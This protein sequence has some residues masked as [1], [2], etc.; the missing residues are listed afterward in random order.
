MLTGF[1]PLFST[2]GGIEWS[3]PD[4]ATVTAAVS[5]AVATALLIFSA[6]FAVR[7]LRDARQTRHGALITDLSRRWDEELIVR[8]QVLYSRYT[9]TGIVTLVEKIYGTTGGASEDELE[10]FYAL[11]AL[12]N[13]VETLA[14]MEQQG[15][16]S[17][18]VI[19]R[20]WGG[21]IASAWVAWER[22][23]R[24][25]RELLPAEPTTYQHFEAL[26][27]GLKKR[28]GAD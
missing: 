8:S 4:W 6:I 18:E 2:A 22:P 7:Q 26:V 1:V 9:E 13:L 19:D 27:A 16:I 23:V 14:V 3:K 25:M 5:T 15:A 17:L 11:L 10:D 12:P 21:T 24:R 28:P 20:M